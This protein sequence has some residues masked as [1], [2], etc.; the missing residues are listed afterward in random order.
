MNNEYVYKI[1]K[2]KNSI[3]EIENE[4]QNNNSPEKTASLRKKLRMWNSIL[5]NST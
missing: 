1:N 4:L 2:I 3:K 5:S